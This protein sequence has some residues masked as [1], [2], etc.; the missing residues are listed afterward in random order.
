MYTVQFY[1]NRIVTTW[2]KETRFGDGAINI[3]NKI[4]KREQRRISNQNLSKH[5]TSVNL[6]ASSKRLIRDSINGMYVLSKPR[7]IKLPNNKIIY[8]YRQ[9]F[10]TLTLPSKQIHTDVEIKSCLNNFLTSLRQSIG[11]KNYVWK[12]ELQQNENIHFHLVID[13]YCSYQA[14]R[15]YWNKAIN[16]LGYVDRYS[17]RFNKLTLKEYCELR[18]IPVNK[19][20]KAY[21]NGKLSKWESPNSVDVVSVRTDR[22][23]SNYLSKYFAK[24]DDSNIDEDRIRAFGRVWSRSQSLSRLKYINKFD[25]SEINSYLKELIASKRGVYVKSYDFCKVIYLS[26]SKVKKSLIKFFIKMLNYNAKNWNYPFP[27]T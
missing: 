10:I 12:A 8:N 1:P 16:K 25:L 27:A 6:S 18:N 13:K 20:I 26:I 24:S 19:G 21:N 14:I 15:H 22:D 11:V 17:E 9:S 4:Y 7:T 23:V 5:K 3:V 2:R